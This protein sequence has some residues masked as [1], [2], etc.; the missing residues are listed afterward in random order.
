MNDSD[1][2][3]T[4]RIGFLSSIS[5]IILLLVS[6]IALEVFIKIKFLEIPD[7]EIYHKVFLMGGLIFTFYMGTIIFKYHKLDL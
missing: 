4:F 3:H 6:E 7:G 2:L 1:K 5:T